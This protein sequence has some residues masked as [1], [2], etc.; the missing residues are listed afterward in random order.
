[1]HKFNY[2]VEAPLTTGQSLGFLNIPIP[3]GSTKLKTK[4]HGLSTRAN[5][6][7]QATAACRRSDCQLVRIE[8]ATWSAWRI[9]PA[10]F[11]VF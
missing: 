3:K 11:S 4:L 8:G 5:Y 10:V 1:M 6:T 2:T 9:P 7:D